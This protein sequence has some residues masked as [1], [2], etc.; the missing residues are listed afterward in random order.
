MTKRTRR[1][2]LHSVIGLL[3][4]VVA[5]GPMTVAMILW[6]R[7]L[8][9]SERYPL[10]PREITMKLAR[11]T[12]LSRHM[13]SETRSAATLLGHF[14]Y[15]GAAGAIYGAASDAVEA[16]TLSKGVVAGLLL[17][18]GSYLGWLP[19]TGVLKAATDHPARRNALMIG[20]HLVWGTAMAGLTHLLQDEA[21]GPGLKPLSTA[22]A[23][24]HD[25]STR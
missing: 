25:V 1:T 13:N 3:A 12:G 8:P 21:E 17:W 6:H 19:G 15:G 4:G 2:A 24:H 11:E 7:R 16:R 18:A 9:A 5:T 23:P 10:P 14:A 22:P 20:A